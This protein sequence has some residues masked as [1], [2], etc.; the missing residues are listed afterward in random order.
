[1]DMIQWK[2]QQREEKEL[3]LTE[4]IHSKTLQDIQQERVI[5]ANLQ[6]SILWCFHM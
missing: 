6:L 3:N 4:E 1:M 2:I 5:N